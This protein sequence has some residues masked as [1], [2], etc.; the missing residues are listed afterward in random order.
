MS[1]VL[2]GA[3]I[4]IVKRLIKKSTRLF[5]GE[6]TYLFG[7][8]EFHKLRKEAAAKGL[9]TVEYANTL[10]TKGLLKA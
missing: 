9:T 4:N 8:R 1:I 7:H 5:K 2:S 10:V 6:Y 3:D